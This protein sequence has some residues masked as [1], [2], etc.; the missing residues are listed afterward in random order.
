MK[1]KLIS[2]PSLGGYYSSQLEHTQH[3]NLHRVARIITFRSYLG[4]LEKRDLIIIIII[5]L[6]IIN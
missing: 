1:N 4:F 6:S 3:S 5:I 2:P